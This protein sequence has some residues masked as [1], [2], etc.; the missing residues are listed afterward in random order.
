MQNLVDKCSSA[1]NI[2]LY[3]I[4]LKLYCCYCCCCFL[5]I[6]KNLVG[7]NDVFL[8]LKTK[9]TTFC[10][11]L[12]IIHAR[13]LNRDIGMRITEFLFWNNGIIPSFGE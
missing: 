5:L 2:I 1:T 7:L 11:L 9:C 10:T 13:A 12:P 3:I 4:I 8:V 6:P